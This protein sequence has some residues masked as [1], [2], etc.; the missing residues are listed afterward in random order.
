MPSKRK[1][2]AKTLP[3]Q[4]RGNDNPFGLLVECA[5]IK[6]IELDSSLAVLT[7]G[8]DWGEGI[9]VNLNTSKARL[10][11]EFLNDG[12]TSEACILE[13]FE[14]Y[15]KCPAKSDGPRGAIMVE[16][17]APQFFEKKEKSLGIDKAGKLAKPVVIGSTAYQ[18]AAIILTKGGSG[19]EFRMGIVCFA[20]ELPDRILPTQ[21]D[22]FKCFCI[23][24]NQWWDKHVE[25]IVKQK[26][27]ERKQLMVECY[28][29]EGI[30]PWKNQ[31]AV[32]RNLTA[33]DYPNLFAAWGKRKFA[34]SEEEK[35]RGLQEI[36][37]AY[38]VDRTAITGKRPLIAVEEEL[39]GN[40]NLDTFILKLAQSMKGKVGSKINSKK[41]WLAI[42][43]TEKKLFR[44]N[45]KQLAKCFIKEVNQTATGHDLRESARRSGL[46]FLLKRGPKQRAT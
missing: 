23:W 2:S 41:W 37:L 3:S 35:K 7:E 45:D 27:D 33:K 38:I 16:G 6:P 36:K 8:W 10:N 32:L 18:Y 34:K 42:N 43:W 11:L 9:T 5:P 40:H 12:G 30:D 13:G 44:M 31:R 14:Y 25:G 21:K 28:N 20:I 39:W 19:S 17:K 24:L 22:R 26:D 46:I 15:E 1:T 4:V 29:P